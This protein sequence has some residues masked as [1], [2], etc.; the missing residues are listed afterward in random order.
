MATYSYEAYH[1]YKDH[2]ICVYCKREKAAPGKV[3]CLNCAS[4]LAEKKRAK[5]NQVSEEEREERNRKK[6]EQSKALRDYRKENGL[7]ITCGKPVYKNYS[8]CYEHY[9]Y[10]KR[11]DRKRREARAKRY[12]EIGLCR[13]CGKPV[14]KGKKFCEEHLEKYRKIMSHAQAIRMEKKKCK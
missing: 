3:M 7:C 11:V 4:I 2:G 6:R 1:Y 12:A 5:Y 8:R 9:I 10:F 14:V 13:I